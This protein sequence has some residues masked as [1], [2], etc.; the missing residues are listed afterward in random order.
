MSIEPRKLL[1]D[2]RLHWV[3]KYSSE[4]KKP[5]YPSTER[6]RHSQE[7]CPF[8]LSRMPLK[9][10]KKKHVYDSTRHLTWSSLE[11][12]RY[13]VNNMNNLVREPTLL[14]QARQWSQ[15]QQSLLKLWK[16]SSQQFLQC[17][18]WVELVSLSRVGRRMDWVSLHLDWQHRP[19]HPGEELVE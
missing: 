5:S 15:Q 12:M 18:H 8:I 16:F 13:K 1:C 9:N 4:N 3:S 7:K 10:V 2:L 11:V 6:F 17:H 14:P 19:H